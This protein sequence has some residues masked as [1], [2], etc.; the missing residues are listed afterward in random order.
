MQK[1]S[2]AFTIIGG[3][4][5]LY[6]YLPLILNV[7]KNLIIIPSRYKKKFDSRSE[8]RKYKDKIRWC[9]T[10][11]GALNQASFAI[12]ATPPKAQRKLIETILGSKSINY[13]ILE[14]PL[15]ENP[16][17]S[18]VVLKRVQSS[19]IKFRIG[20]TFLYT[21]WFKNLKKNLKNRRNINRESLKISWSFQADHFVKNKDT[22]KKKHSLGGGAIRFY[23]IHCLAVLAA[24]GYEKV[25]SSVL[26]YLKFDEPNIWEAEFS[27]KLLPNCQIQIQTNEPNSIF[28]IEIYRPNNSHRQIYKGISPFF[29]TSPLTE[30]DPRTSVIERLYN[31]LFYTKMNYKN[32]YKSTNRL[33]QA[34]E[35]FIQIK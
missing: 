20:Y 18:A 28:S 24:L 10:V 34:S 29:S 13:L 30:Q 31:S 16:I 6:G 2:K 23:G 11:K 12:I 7:S 27:G 25:K 8:L 17:D 33:W 22:W 5:G 21:D 4:F 1:D 9:T 19:K 15:C 35:N 26:H 32:I 3:G 14:K